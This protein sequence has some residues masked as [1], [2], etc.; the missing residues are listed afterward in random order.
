MNSRLYVEQ[1]WDGNHFSFTPN[2]THKLI[3]SLKFVGCELK[4]TSL[5]QSV[6]S[7]RFCFFFKSV[8]YTEYYFLFFTFS[9]TQREY[10]GHAESIGKDIKVT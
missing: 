7:Q 8:P 2:Q 4:S 9:Y 6:Q 3:Q 10:L 1:L 5:Q